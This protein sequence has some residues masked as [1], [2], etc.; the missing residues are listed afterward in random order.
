L[1]AIKEEKERQLEEMVRI[2]SEQLQQI[3]NDKMHTKAELSGEITSQ[4]I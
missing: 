1:R 3:E 4:K 2:Q